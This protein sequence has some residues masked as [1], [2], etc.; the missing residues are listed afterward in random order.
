MRKFLFP[1]ILVFT[2]FLVIGCGTP[3]GKLSFDTDLPPEKTTEVRFSSTIIVRQYN[4]ID[5][6]ETWY[7]KGKIRGNI[8]SLPA[9][10]T[11]ITFDINAYIQVGNVTTHVTAKNIT[12]NFDFDAGKSYSI[13][14]YSEGMGAQTF[15]LGRKKFGIAIWDNAVKHN[16][17]VE[18]SLKHWEMGQ[19]S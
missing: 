16:F 12:L 17:N 1:V 9:G 8:I 6:F 10:N 18:K 3:P 15:F 7:P 13:A 19:T 14:V 4:G 11:T 2:L 5:V